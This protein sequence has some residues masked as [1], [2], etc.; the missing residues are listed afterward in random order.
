M[1]IT[2]T[3]NLLGDIMFNDEAKRSRAISDMEQLM[4]TQGWIILQQV[5]LARIRALEMLCASEETTEEQSKEYRRRRTLLMSL[6]KIPQ[7][8]IR[9]CQ[10]AQQASQENFDPYE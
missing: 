8:I 6:I 5:L 4:S 3:D 7:N 1:N 2:N 10:A 9:Y